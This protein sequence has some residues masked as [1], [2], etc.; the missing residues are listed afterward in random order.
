MLKNLALFIRYKQIIF[1]LFKCQSK[2]PNKMESEKNDMRVH[3][4]N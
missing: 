2:I 3:N 1:L 4:N